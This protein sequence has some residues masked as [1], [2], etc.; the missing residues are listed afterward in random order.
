MKYLQISNQ[1]QRYKI[2]QLN[3]HL[4]DEKMHLQQTYVLNILSYRMK[5]LTLHKETERHT[6]RA[7][8]IG[9]LINKKIETEKTSFA[10]GGPYKTL[11]GLSCKAGGLQRRRAL[12]SCI[13]GVSSH[14]WASLFNIQEITTHVGAVS[15]FFINHV[16]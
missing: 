2:I 16:K 11:S 3:V 5:I 15:F 10:N 12:K 7:S 8:L 6:G 14:H 1:L 9:I 4:F 13:L